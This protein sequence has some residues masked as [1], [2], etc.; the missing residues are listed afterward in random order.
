MCST[1]G[2]GAGVGA[3][4]LKIVASCWSAAWCSSVKG[5]SGDAACGCSKAWMRDWADAVAASTD[6][7]RGRGTW[8]GNLSSVWA[9]RSLPVASSHTLKHR[10]PRTACGDQVPRW[11]G[12]S[13]IRTLVPGGPRG[14]LLNLLWIPLVGIYLSSSAEVR[15]C[16]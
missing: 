9:M 15:Y 12:S 2:A 7:V 1:L 4:E 16:H 8:L 14:V 10:Q 6:T 13:W 5:V 3:A 11:S